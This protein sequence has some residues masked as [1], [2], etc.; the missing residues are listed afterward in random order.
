MRREN[1]AWN[2]KTSS[3]MKRLGKYA[4]ITRCYSGVWFPTV[5]CIPNDPAP[6]S[7]GPHHMYARVWLWAP[8]RT[9]A[10]PEV[11]RGYQRSIILSCRHA[12]ERP[13]LRQAGD[14]RG[15][16]S[17]RPQNHGRSGRVAE[18]GG[19]AAPHARRA[20]RR[21]RGRAA[22]RCG[23]PAGGRSRLPPRNP[24]RIRRD[25]GILHRRAGSRICTWLGRLRAPSSVL[26][27]R[28]R[29]TRHCDAFISATA[30]VPLLFSNRLI[31]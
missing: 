6:R 5:L 31:M 18:R 14:P 17:R 10:A 26:R 12:G 8:A 27:Y 3:A 11:P 1:Q 13:A 22:R 16:S 20:P 24:L 28:S 4:Y 7:R 19:A 25:R 30:L 21:A 23:S 2:G 9:H 15:R 29:Q